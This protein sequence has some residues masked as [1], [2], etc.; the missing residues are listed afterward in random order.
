MQET[1]TK[2]Q[3]LAQLT[4]SGDWT[5]HSLELMGDAAALARRIG[6]HAGAW[7]LPPFPSDSVLESLA[8]YGCQ[9]VILVNHERLKIWASE[10]VSASLA[11]AIPPH[12]RLILLPGNARGEEVAIWL[13]GLL[14]GVWIP[15]VLTL[16]ATRTGIIEI[17]ATLP[18]GRL[19][20]TYRK[21]SSGPTIVTLRE[22]V[23]EARKQTPSPIIRTEIIPDLTAV[24]ELTRILQS[25]PADPKTLNITHARRIVAAGRGVGGPEG[26]ALVEKFGEMLGASL[27]ASRMAVDLG[28]VSQDRQVGQTGKS[29]KPE[30]YVAC[31]ISGATHHL[32]G[33]RESKH[34]VAINSDPE[35]PIHEVAS[36]SLRADLNSVIPKVEE[37]LFRRSK[38]EGNA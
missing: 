23:A 28:W 9:E 7:V 18:G 26:V 32:A 4:Q 1:S 10:T 31:G 2:I 33:M 14:D 36:L 19:S 21:D 3:I 30:L 37:I 27:A 6:G 34:I 5:P 8:L 12:C 24:P 17:T 20:R 35:A 38:K 25:V 16:S 22:G 13:S 29:V 15:D 11:V